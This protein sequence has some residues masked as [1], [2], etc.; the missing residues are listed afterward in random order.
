MLLGWG[1]LGGGDKNVIRIASM[2]KTLVF[3]ASVYNIRHTHVE[4]ENLSQA[5]MPFATKT[6]LSVLNVSANPKAL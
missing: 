1:G 3:T 2:H 6:V 4:Q 5:S